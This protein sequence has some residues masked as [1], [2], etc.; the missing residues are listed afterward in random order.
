MGASS[1]KNDGSQTFSLDKAKYTSM[2][3]FGV[4]YFF[5]GYLLFIGVYIG[6][7]FV[8]RATD[9]NNEYLTQN[10][11]LRPLYQMLRKCDFFKES[12]QEVS[13][14][15]FF[16]SI[17]L[18]IYTILFL[19][20]LKDIMKSHLYNQLFSTVQFNMANNPTNNLEML[21]KIQDKPSSDILTYLIKTITGLIFL[22]GYPFL[23]LYLIRCYDVQNNIVTQVALFSIL[24][25][26]IIYYVT[27]HLVTMK[28]L[29]NT[30]DF[31]DY[32]KKYMES[33][34]YA[35]VDMV[36]DKFNFNFD[37]ILFVPLLILFVSILYFFMYYEINFENNQMVLYISLFLF[38]VPAIILIFNY[39]V[40]FSCYTDDNE[41]GIFRNGLIKYEV[42]HNGIKSYYDALVKYNYLCFPK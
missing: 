14:E 1:S 22:L 39:N 3:V 37:K 38:I 34:D 28:K 36:K 31:M 17:L 2:M 12:F 6:F 33:K 29:Y 40:L 8:L 20:L 15:N 32:G 5:L 19:L 7:F 11:I 30:N 16:K 18:F 35:Y 27:T 42:Y 4:L 24:F 26:P 23:V 25:V 41:C 13:I 10:I 21:S 9:L